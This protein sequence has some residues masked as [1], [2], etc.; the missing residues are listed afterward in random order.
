M[1]AFLGRPFYWVNSNLFLMASTTLDHRNHTFSMR[2]ALLPLSGFVGSFIAGLL[3]ALFATLFGLS[4]DEA[5][6]YR[7]ALFL[8]GLVYLPALIAMIKT[9][10]VDNL[11]SETA[12]V[13]LKSEVAEKFPYFLVLPLMLVNILRVQQ[14]LRG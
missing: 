12:N 5:A 4:T 10:E 3:P 14:R 2:T 1:I 6:P 11:S 9:A 13:D 7:Y 8:A